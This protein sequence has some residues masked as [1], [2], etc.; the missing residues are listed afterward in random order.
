MPIY[1]CSNLNLPSRVALPMVGFGKQKFTV[2]RS[3]RLSIRVRGQTEFPV[4]FDLY[5]QCSRI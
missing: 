1:F 3:I 5:Y 2:L 4:P